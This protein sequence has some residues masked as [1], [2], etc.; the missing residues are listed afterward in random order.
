[1]FFFIFTNLSDQK[2]FTAKIH[3]QDRYEN[4]KNHLQLDKYCRFHFCS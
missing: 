4:S 3:K 2:L 1:M